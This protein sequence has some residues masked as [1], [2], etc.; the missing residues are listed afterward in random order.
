MHKLV[1]HVAFFYREE[2]LDYI[3]KII[4]ESHKYPFEIVDVFIHTNRPFQ[5]NEENSTVNIIVHYFDDPFA[6]TWLCRPL[7]HEQKDTYDAFM[8]IEDDI[9]VPKEAIHYWQELSPLLKKM[10]YNLGFVRIEIKDG[11]EFITDLQ[12]HEKFSDFLILNGTQLYVINNKNPYCAFWIYS[13]QDFHDFISS[14]YYDVNN[15][16]NYD[17]RARCAIGLHGFGMSYYDATLIPYDKKNGLDERCRIYHLPNNY[18]NDPTS[19]FAKIKF[20]ECYLSVP[21]T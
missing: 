13:K 2:R 11:T 19:V 14:N 9:L 18:V 3:H 16:T 12:I 17:S 20:N 5:L 6:L 7:M 1:I 15:I 21:F 4:H 8:Y 10:F